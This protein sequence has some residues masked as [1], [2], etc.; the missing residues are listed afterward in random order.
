MNRDFKDTKNINR[1]PDLLDPSLEVVQLGV[2]RVFLTKQASW[3][4]ARCRRWRILISTVKRLTID[5]YT[6]APILFPSLCLSTLFVRVAPVILWHLFNRCLF[7]IE[8]GLTRGEFDTVAIINAVVARV[9]FAAVVAV[10]SYWSRKAEFIVQTRIIQHFEAI[11][12]EWKSRVDL[13]TSE[14]HPEHDEEDVIAG[15][16]VWYAYRDLVVGVGR[17]LSIISQLFYVSTLTHTGKEALIYAILFLMR[18]LAK[19]LLEPSLWDRVWIATSSEPNFNRMASLK[20]IVSEP[21]YR[22]EI[23]SNGDIKEYL[24]QE[25]LKAR[26]FLRDVS[27][28][29]PAAQ[30]SNRERVDL[31]VLSELLGDLHMFYCFASAILNPSKLMV[32]KIAMLPRAGD[33]VTTELD[34]LW[35]DLRDSETN[36]AS[37]QR[38]YDLV[39]A[40]NTRKDGKFDIPSSDMGMSLAMRNVSFSYPNKKPNEGALHDISCTIKPGQLVVIVGENGS[41]KSTLLKL[42]TRLYD[43]TSGEVSVDGTD[44][45]DYKF[46]SLRSATAMLTQDHRL[47]PLSLSENIG[48]GNP[49]AASDMCLIQESARKGGADEFICDKLAEKYDTVLE[50]M[51]TNLTSHLFYTV[52]DTPLNRI[53]NNFG[54]KTQISG[55][56]RQRLVASRAFMRLTTGKVRLIVADEPSSNLDPKGESELFNNLIDERQGKTMIFVTHRF[57]FLTEHADLILC[58]KKGRLVE[59]GTHDELMT[60]GEDG[61]YFKLYDLQARVFKSDI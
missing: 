2:W 17:T 48:V 37:V 46:G 39:H 6:L 40:D 21:E 18:P 59:Q 24:C 9:V 15:H 49:E 29:Y 23:N 61:E 26:N 56:E 32:S 38:V 20:S 27:A 22:Q 52:D 14:A 47:F 19:D 11:V 8:I 43:C 42:F 34:A 25:Y 3:F 36:L 50:P 60:M 1:D 57:G 28:S 54:K 58:M 12:F 55:G 35:V 41:G 51:A 53:Y 10:I 45:R 44:I 13:S 31:A 7:M 5:F 33:L 30:Y 4:K 16:D